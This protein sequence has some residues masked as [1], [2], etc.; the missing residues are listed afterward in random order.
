M[1][2]TKIQRKYR[3]K[4][5]IGLASCF[6]ALVASLIFTSRAADLPAADQALTTLRKGNE[7]FASGRPAYPHEGAARR[8]AVASGQH[9]IATVLSCSDSRVPPEILFDEGIGD[10]FVVRVIG[11]I[12]GADEVGS[13]EYGVEHLGTPLLLV[14]GHSQCGAVTAAV[15]HAEVR[16]NIPRLLAHIKPAVEI[17]RR[18][19]PELKGSALVPEAVRVNVFQSIAELFKR[20]AIIRDHV[21]TG[22]LKVVGAIYDINSGFVNYL[23][24]HP[25]QNVF[26]SP[27]IKS[28]SPEKRRRG[29]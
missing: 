26:L 5:A 12:G 19:H 24:V 3:L 22:K 2:D 21:R 7:R 29:R 10:L 9:P 15:T 6:S 4:L 25:R 18:A 23:G 1:I 20:S 28:Y 17:A 8:A 11:N 16:G 27:A 13:V 14:L